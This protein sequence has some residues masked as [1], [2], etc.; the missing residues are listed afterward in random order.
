MKGNPCWQ[1]QRSDVSSSWPPGLL[2]SLE[3]F[4]SIPHC[5]SSPS[6]RFRGWRLATR[7]VSSLHRLS[8]WLRSGD[9]LSNSRTLMCF[10]L[11]QSFVALAVCFWL[12]SCWNTHLC[13]RVGDEGMRRGITNA[14]EWALLNNIKQNKQQKLPRKG[15]PWKLARRGEAGQGRAG[16]GRTRQTGHDRIPPG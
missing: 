16:Q 6:I 10:F 12:F 13:V 9:C 7:T 8:M 2:T 3:G 1:S 4:Y 15:K 5:R 14:G 11:S